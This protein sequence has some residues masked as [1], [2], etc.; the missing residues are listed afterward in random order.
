[1]DYD[2]NNIESMLKNGASD[3]DIARAFTTALNSA[4]AAD[5]KRRVEEAEAKKREAEKAA[6]AAAKQEARKAKAKAAADAMNEFMRFEGLP[7]DEDTIFTAENLIEIA[8]S[9]KS[10]FKGLTDAFASLI[11]V[12]D[13]V[14]PLDKKFTKATPADKKYAKVDIPITDK[15]FANK[16]DIPDK[17]KNLSDEDIFEDFL[18]SIFR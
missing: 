9:T 15:K 8:D 1:M 3:A 2:F 12:L 16:V 13:E 10:E 17:S 18:K 14:A 5:A 4:K 11:R 7:L 6:A